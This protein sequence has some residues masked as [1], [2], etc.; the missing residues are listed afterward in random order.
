MI[1]KLLNK[2]SKT[3]VIADTLDREPRNEQMRCTTILANFIDDKNQRTDVA[4]N[5]IKG[6]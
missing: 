1:I 2:S 4:K 5:C 6:T 3:N